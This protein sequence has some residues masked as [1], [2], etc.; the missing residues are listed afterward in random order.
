MSEATT[1]APRSLRPWFWFLLFLTPVL[2]IAG[3]GLIAVRQGG[4]T[5]LPWLISFDLLALPSLGLVCSALCAIHLS[6]VRTGRVHLGWTLGSLVGFAALNLALG[7]GGCWLGV[8]AGE[9]L[10][11]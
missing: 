7:F 2:S 5:E 6:R 8:A 3:N 10:A 11:K 1:I 9:G 4:E